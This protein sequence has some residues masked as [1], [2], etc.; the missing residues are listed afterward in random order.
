MPINYPITVDAVAFKSQ[1]VLR[2]GGYGADTGDY[3]SVRPCAEE[4]E[5]KTYLGI[6]I[7][8]IALSQMV[9]Y[10]EE[11]KTL[12]IT[13]AMYNPAIF[14]PDLKKVIFGAESYWHFIEDENSLREVTNNDIENVWYV[15]A[16][17]AM[18]EEKAQEQD[19]P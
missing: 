6:M 2:P 17:K 1:E 12:S 4:Y 16:L 5:N 15:Q 8:D 7:G 10:N 11:T 18:T 19:Q 3:V 9:S 14:V 13:R